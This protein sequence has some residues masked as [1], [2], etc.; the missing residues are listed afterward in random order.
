MLYEE[1][2]TSALVFQFPS[3]LNSEFIVERVWRD[4]SRTN[5]EASGKPMFRKRD[6]PNEPFDIMQ[7]SE[8]KG[9]ENSCPDAEKP[10]HS[11][12]G[13]R[14]ELRAAFPVERFHE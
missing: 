3:G 12:T 7:K 5:N 13:S 10:F 6:L 9:A 8:K 2:V 11:F 14:R 1:G 4:T